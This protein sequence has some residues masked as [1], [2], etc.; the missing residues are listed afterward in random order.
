MISKFYNKHKLSVGNLIWR[1]IQIFFKQGMQ[2]IVL[3]YFARVLAP[4]EFGKYNYAISILL[5]LVTFSD[6]GISAAVSKF[7]SEYS[8]KNKELEKHLFF[9]SF[10]ILTFFSI[11]IIIISFFLYLYLPLRD[12]QLLIVYLIPSVFFAPITSLLDGIYRGRK[13]FKKLSIINV[14]CGIIYFILSFFLVKMHGIIGALISYNFLFILLSIFLFFGLKSIEIKIN[15]KLIKKIFSYSIYIGL[16]TIGYFLYTKVDII[17]LEMFGYVNEIGFYEIVNQTFLILLVPFIL[18]S[19]ILAPNITINVASS[20]QKIVLIKLKR[21]LLWFIPLSVILTL[22]LYLSAPHVINLILK[23]YYTPE[24]LITLN[25]LLLVLP[26]KII[27]VVL[28]QSFILSTG[29]ARYTT[30]GT[31]IGGFLN[32]IFD[33]IFIKLFGYVGVFY[34]TVV[35]HT[36]TITFTS[37][38]FYRKIKHVYI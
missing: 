4:T 17:V 35:I 5:L 18:Y 3:L 36:A 38:L 21:N 27:G 16:S 22:F 1:V 9:N 30:Y 26:A 6:F 37:I 2:Y 23:D 15:M 34:S 33:F 29:Y 11:I 24:M 32:L 12:N 8:V 31:L 13:D 10:V 7:T 19:Q 20:D 25:I 28:S 14:F